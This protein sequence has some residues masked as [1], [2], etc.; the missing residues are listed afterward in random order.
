MKEI[1]VIGAG[2]H[3]RVVADV[4]RLSG[5]Y[6]IRGFLDQLH[7]ARHGDAFEGARILGG[8]DLLPELLQDGVAAVVAIGDNEA[9]RRIGEDLLRRGFSLAVLIHPTA[10]V[11]GSVEIGAGTVVFA[12]AIVNPA[13]RIGA[14]VI[15]NT[16]ATIDHDCAIGDAVHVAPGV[17]IAG[18][19]TIGE[20]TLI[21]VGA[22]IKPGVT[23]GHNAVV[24]VGAAVVADVAD[25][26][27]VAG[28]PA[29]VLR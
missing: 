3:A 17:H 29:H 7:G 20:G 4:I 12:G 5:A 19:V 21:G 1:V 16:A 13:T 9:R 2:G 27:T 10:T 15:I 14:H 11:A 8:D 22:A 28:V 25:G 23:V 18:D 24:G 26:V 6:Q